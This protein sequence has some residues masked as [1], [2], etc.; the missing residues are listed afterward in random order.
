MLKSLST[1]HGPGSEPRYSMSCVRMSML[2]LARPM[3]VTKYRETTCSGT[4]K[5]TSR[6]TD[7][8]RCDG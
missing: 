4:A 3:L 7:S 8:T 6:R 2:C 1:I 5:P